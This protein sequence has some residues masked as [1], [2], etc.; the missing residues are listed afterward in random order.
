MVLHDTR[1]HGII[2]ITRRHTQCKINS[3]NRKTQGHLS[4]LGL[5]KV[6]ELLLRSWM[7]LSIHLEG[8]IQKDVLCIWKSQ[9]LQLRTIVKN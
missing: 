9:G 3:Q 2:G 4:F 8:D 5:E 6:K 1:Q 7:K